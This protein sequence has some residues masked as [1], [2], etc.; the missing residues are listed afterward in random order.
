VPRRV[1]VFG[2]IL[3][4]FPFSIANLA[5]TLIGF[6]LVF[7]VIPLE[8]YLG[9]QL[10]LNVMTLIWIFLICLPVIYLASAIQIVVASFARTPKEAG[11]YLPFIALIPSLPGL[12]LAFFPVK[13]NLW[14]MLIPT[15][16]QQ[17][18][19]NQLL[20]LEPISAWNIITSVL[21]TLLVSVLF[22]WLGILLYKREQV[23]FR[24]G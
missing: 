4:S 8:K 6:G 24:G 16:G 3:S 14:L 17:L 9:M 1:F 22:T 11:N 21:A 5:L 15:F 20:R 10:G 7:N 12:A 18:L 23:M 2:K 13:S 19:I